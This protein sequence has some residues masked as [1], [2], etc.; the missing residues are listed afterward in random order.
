MLQT[1]RDFGRFLRALW[2]EGKALV[3]GG[4]LFAAIAIWG[5][6]TGKSV[7]TN[8]AYLALAATFI[9][10]GF[11][12]WRKEA[13]EA[14]RLR[15]VLGSTHE[16]ERPDLIFVEEGPSFFVQLARPHTSIQAENLLQ[17][18][19]GKWMKLSNVTVHDV[20]TFGNLYIVSGMSEDGITLTMYFEKQWS[21]RILI[22]RRDSKIG[23][24]GQI[25]AVEFGVRLEN[26]EILRPPS[27]SPPELTSPP[28][29]T[30]K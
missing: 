1:L 17:P 13:R 28:P 21:E 18:Y 8:I 19:M 12:A 14:D 30:E 7:P 16:K 2:R 24:I 4:G 5:L 11:L 27:S 25:R 20:D 10:A 9:W 22:L 6:V 26:C 15:T 3:M 23:I 29:T